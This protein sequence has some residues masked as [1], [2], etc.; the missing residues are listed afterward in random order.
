[1]ECRE[2]IN[3]AKARNLQDFVNKFRR[4]K[5]SAPL[6][7]RKASWEARVLIRF[8][9]PMIIHVI[10]D[11]PQQ[12]LSARVTDIPLNKDQIQPKFPARKSIPQCST[13]GLGKIEKFLDGLKAST[14]I[15]IGMQK[16]LAPS[17]LLRNLRQI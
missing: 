17:K 5:D 13:F 9:S 1:M 7:F 14:D 2:T 11:P 4:L 10:E 8:D 16:L 3:L 6:D 15:T 12:Q